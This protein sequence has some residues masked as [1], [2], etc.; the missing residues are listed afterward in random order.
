MSHKGVEPVERYDNI[1]RMLIDLIGY[2]EE[3]ESAP[4]RAYFYTKA[5]ARPC[6]ASCQ[7]VPAVVEEEWAWTPGVESVGLAT[8]W[9]AKSA[10]RNSTI[11]TEIS[12]TVV[13]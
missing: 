3:L 10:V 13:D 6:S 11:A 8:C 9:A 7:K 12:R 5:A 1:K 4:K 2:S